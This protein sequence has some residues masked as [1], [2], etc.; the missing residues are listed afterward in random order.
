MGK[1]TWLFELSTIMGYAY[2]P[3]ED[4]DQNGQYH[5]PDCLELQRQGA[6][7]GA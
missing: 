4:D 2:L 7:G 1:C 6:C 3:D 5:V